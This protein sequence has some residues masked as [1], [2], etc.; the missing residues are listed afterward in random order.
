[1]LNKRFQTNIMSGSPGCIRERG[2]FA[3]AHQVRSGPGQDRS[4]ARDDWHA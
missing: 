2:A 3:G 4:A 1:V